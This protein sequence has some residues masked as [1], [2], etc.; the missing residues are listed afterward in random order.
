MMKY[1]ITPN[2]GVAASRIS[3]SRKSRIIDMMIAPIQING[4]RTTSRISMATASCSWFT[5]FV[6]RLISEG[7]PKMSSSA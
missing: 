3:D 6:I 1:K 2:T 4:A 7:V 5:S